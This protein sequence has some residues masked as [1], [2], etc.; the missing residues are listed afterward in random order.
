MSQNVNITVYYPDGALRL[1]LPSQR[2]FFSKKNANGLVRRL[3][4]SAAQMLQHEQLRRRQGGE[5]EAK[6]LMSQLTGKSVN[7]LYS[8]PTYNLA[9]YLFCEPP[10]NTPCLEL[11]HRL[12]WW[13]D[14]ANDNRASVLAVCQRHYYQCKS[15]FIVTATGD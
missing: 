7:Q 13:K 5:Q 1:S 4:A 12:D 3:F 8:L 9:A 10:F 2:E 6:D 14:R 15:K 11:E